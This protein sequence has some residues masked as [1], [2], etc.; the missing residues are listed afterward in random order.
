MLRARC[1]SALARAVFPD[2]LFGVY[3]PDEMG[4][5]VVPVATATVVE[6]VDPVGQA[7]SRSTVYH[8]RTV[9]AP[10]APH[11]TEAS[12][13]APELPA[14]VVEAAAAAADALDVE[15]ADLRESIAAAGHVDV[16]AALVPR[17][18]KLPAAD[19]DALRPL[20]NERKAAL[21]AGAQVA[22]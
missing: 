14:H 2:L 4:G 15:V 16:L 3:D 17:L 9:E 11:I 18:A 1:S 5:A 20:F 6:S 21:A 10:P 7:E 22:G 13:V 12:A 19:R 8:E